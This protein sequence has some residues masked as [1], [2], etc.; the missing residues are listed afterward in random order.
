MESKESKN[1]KYMKQ[2]KHNQ[3]QTIDRTL[4]RQAIEQESHNRAY[5]KNQLL[6]NTLNNITQNKQESNNRKYLEQ[7]EKRINSNQALE[8]P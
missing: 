5:I 1:R 6:D 7:S 2:S 3:N 8:I 4:N